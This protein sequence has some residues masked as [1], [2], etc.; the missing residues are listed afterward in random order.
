MDSRRGLQMWGP[1]GRW[2]FLNWPR[3]SWQYDVICGAIIVGLFVLPNAPA[4][5][6]MDVDEVLAA[7]AAADAESDSFT[8]DMSSTERIVLFAAEETATGPVA[9]LQPASFR[10]QVTDPNDRTEVIADNKVTVYIPR[11]KQAQIIS[12]AGSMDEG[13]DLV[14]PGLASSSELKS[15]YEV[16][17]EGVA[18][19][20]GARVYTLR[21]VPKPGTTPAKHY[22]AITLQVAEGEWHPA[23]SIILESYVGDTNTIVLTNVVRNAGLEPDDF[24]LDL[25]A[26]TEIVSRGGVSNIP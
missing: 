2:V 22:R 19:D 6:Q 9:F 3:G 21:L 16:S 18:E 20:G 13:Q 14:I 1:V 5:P 12:I 23:R 7:I 8:A 25:P 10:R 26:D 11:I 15:A 17:L 24:K 4:A